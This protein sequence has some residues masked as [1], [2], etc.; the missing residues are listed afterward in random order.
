MRSR[1]LPVAGTMLVLAVLSACAT[2]TA[3][4]AAPGTAFRDCPDCPEMVVLPP[5]RFVM[6][7][8][9]AETEREHVPAPQAVVE[10]PAHEVAIAY[11]LAI[12]RSEVT[13][14]QYAAFVRATKRPETPCLV[15][16]D[17]AWRTLP[18][19]SW[20]YAP[21]PQRDD[22][23][24][25]CVSW[26]DA[27]AYAAWLSQRAGQRYRLPSEAE[28]EYAARAGTTT[29]RYWGDGVDDAC[30]WAN[31]ADRGSPRPQFGCDDGWRFT[32]PALFGRPNAFGLY[33][34]LGNVGEWTADCGL[35]DY[36]T[37]PRDGSVATG[38]DCTTHTGRGGSW[39]NDAYYIRAARRFSMAGSYF[40]VGFRVVRELRAAA[41]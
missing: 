29:A 25:I 23:P 38:A 39:W 17:K 21:F 41:P 11:P 7:S 4:L 12:G 5:G 19:S 14:A 18:G 27:A 31:V 35:S 20:D 24:A 34:M 8:T 40:I 28:W 16:L 26:D 10:H 37:A 30:A 36:A 3:R 22:H 9:E 2:P 1:R 32:A 15:Y 33:G 13:R 6:G